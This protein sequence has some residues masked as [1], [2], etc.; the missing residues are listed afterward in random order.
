MNNGQGMPLHVPDLGQRQ[1]DAAAWAQENVLGTAGITPG[2][3]GFVETVTMGPVIALTEVHLV[4][5]AMPP[6]LHIIT[7]VGKD[8][9][10]KPVAIPWHAVKSLRGA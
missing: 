2:G 6:E 9:N 8:Q 7:L 4:I 5:M 10:G 3:A 1:M